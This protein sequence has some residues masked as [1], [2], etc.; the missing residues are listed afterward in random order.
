V[1]SGVNIGWHLL[2]GRME[3][4]ILAL[5]FHL[6]D[7][8]CLMEGADLCVCQ[9]RDQAALESAESAFD[10]AFCLR[11]WS[12]QVCNVQGAQGSLELASRVAAVVGRAWAE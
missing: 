2:C 7:L 9:K 4:G 1:G 12:D 5:D 11:G 8:V 3:G 6:E 10:F